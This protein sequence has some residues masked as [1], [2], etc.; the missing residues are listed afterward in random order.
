MTSPPIRPAFPTLATSEIDFVAP[1][2]S[3]AFGALERRMD[4]ENGN[5]DELAR[6]A[7]FAASIARLVA[8]WRD[9]RQAELRYSEDV[10]E[11]RELLVVTRGELLDDS[12][13]AAR[14]DGFFKRTEGGL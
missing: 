10:A 9:G 7:T 14:I 13:T 3:A 8:N 5:K 4:A 12:N 2:L 6:L 11:M 1:G